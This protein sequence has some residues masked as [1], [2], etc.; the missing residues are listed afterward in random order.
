MK[1][2][3]GFP[4]YL[5]TLHYYLLPQ[6]QFIGLLFDKLQLA[7]SFAC[8]TDYFPKYAATVFIWSATRTWKGQRVSQRPQW[9]QSEACFSRA[10]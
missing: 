7:E 9:M 4:P 5:F 3:E 10:P 1:E 8:L 6:L 2:T